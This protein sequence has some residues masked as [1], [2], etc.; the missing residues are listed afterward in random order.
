M[1]SSTTS[2]NW[3]LVGQWGS[4]ISSAEV[5]TLGFL[6]FLLAACWCCVTWSLHLLVTF[7]L[8]ELHDVV[9]LH[10]LLQRQFQKC[11]LLKALEHSWILNKAQQK[12]WLAQVLDQTWSSIIVIEHLILLDF[13][14]IFGKLS[15]KDFVAMDE[16]HR[17]FH[18]VIGKCYK[19][20]KGFISILVLGWEKTHSGRIALHCHHSNLCGDVLVLNSGLG[21]W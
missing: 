6:H 17:C 20:G 14:C 18:A 10:I 7:S 12:Q 9:V 5:P 13:P 2:A 16:Y 4:C 21:A 1:Y 3:I 15:S 8:P 11:Y 19:D